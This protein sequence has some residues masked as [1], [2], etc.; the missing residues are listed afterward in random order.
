MVVESRLTSSGHRGPQPSLRG[1][2]F[3][4]TPTISP[5]NPSPQP[6]PLAGV[7]GPLSALSPA[8]A[9]RV[10]GSHRSASTSGAAGTRKAKELTQRRYALHLLFPFIFSN[11]ISFHQHNGKTTVTSLL[12]NNIMESLISGNFSV[13]VF[14]NI[15]ELTFIFRPRVFSAPLPSDIK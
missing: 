5:H 4:N 10:R 2:N 3:L 15:M 12:F 7:R 13:C 14:N 1:D 8:G 9:G 6:S 11:S